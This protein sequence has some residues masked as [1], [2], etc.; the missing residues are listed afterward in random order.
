MACLRASG[1]AAP[2]VDN[3]ESGVISFLQAGGYS[4]TSS[5]VFKIS[6]ADI[7]VRQKASNRIRLLEGTRCRGTSAYSSL[8]RGK[9]GWVVNVGAQINYAR[10]VFEV[11]A[12]LGDPTTLPRQ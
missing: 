12:L 11:D 10:G 9:C 1:A 8:S 7:I 2:K 3:F 5:T 6:S 4:N